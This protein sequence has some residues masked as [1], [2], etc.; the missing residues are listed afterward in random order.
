[1]R[2]KSES[3]FGSPEVLFALSVAVLVVV[4]VTTSTSRVAQMISPASRTRPNTLG[5]DAPSLEDCT[6]RSAS[7]PTCRVV[8]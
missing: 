1:M 2:M 3:R 5:I 6:E 7:L 8:L 4:V